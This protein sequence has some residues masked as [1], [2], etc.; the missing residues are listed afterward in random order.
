MNYNAHSL[1]IRIVYELG[2]AGF[3]K[4]NKDGTFSCNEPTDLV[5]KLILDDERFIRESLRF[6]QF[7]SR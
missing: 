1:A 5:L 7:F 6:N 3:M 2:R 4:E